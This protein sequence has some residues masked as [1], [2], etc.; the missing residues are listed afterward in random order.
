MKLFPE[1]PKQKTF[2]AS[3]HRLEL[4]CVRSIM[5]NQVQYYIMSRFIINQ[6]E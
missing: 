5:F 1:I 6:I 4:P 3:I 2:K